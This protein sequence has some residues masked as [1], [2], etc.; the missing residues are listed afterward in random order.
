MVNV[1]TPGIEPNRKAKLTNRWTYNCFFEKEIKAGTERYE[2]YYKEHPSHLQADEDFKSKPGLL[3]EGSTS[4][5]NTIF[6]SAET[7]FDIVR[8]LHKGTNGE[9]SDNKV[10]VDSK[11]ITDYIKSWSKKLGAINIGV[12]EL[13]KHHF[14]SHYGRENN[15]GE[16]VSNN[17]KYAIVF[18]VEMDQ[19]TMSTAPAAPT[20]MESAQQYVNAGMIAVTI[21]S[22]IRKLGFPAKAHIDES[23]DVVCPPIALDAGLGEFGR[24]GL[25]IT[26]ELGPRV[27]LAVV[28]TDIPLITNERKVDNSVID[29]CEKC[30]KCANICPT[31]AIPFDKQKIIDGVMKWQINQDACF[32]FW[33]INGTDCGR[34]VSVCPYSHPNNTFHNFIRWGIKNSSLFRSFAL[35]M[36]DLFYGKKPP[37]A[38]TPNW[39]KVD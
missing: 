6:K 36:D 23:Y 38:K 21:S 28:T 2:N 24:L 22:F 3:S 30:K 4:F 8:L 19:E 18:T 26:P 27:R 10:N 32:K 11:Q 15:Y 37:T 25:L 31:D 5:D 14:Y 29:F 34:C 20:I 39:M 7:C 9:I 35:K 13:K 16:K 12:T 33:C 17:H 1:S